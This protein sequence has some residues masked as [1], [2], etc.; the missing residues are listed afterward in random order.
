MSVDMKMAGFTNICFWLAVVSS[1]TSLLTTS[2]RSILP[3]I[4]AWLL[5]APM[6]FLGLTYAMQVTLLIANTA[7]IIHLI[8]YACFGERFINS[9][10]A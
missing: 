2:L 9:N 5:V 6:Y 7:L 10:A 8:S 4:A 1:C 3:A